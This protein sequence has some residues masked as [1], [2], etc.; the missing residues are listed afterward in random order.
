MRWL[1]RALF[2]ILL[3]VFVAFPYGPLFPWSRVTPGYDRLRLERADILHP[4]D[5]ALDPSYQDVDRFIAE[6]EQFHGLNMPQ[7]VTVVACRDW[8]DFQRFMPNMRSHGVGAVT[9]LTGTVIYVTP[10]IRERQL[11]NGEFL[12]HE[13]SHAALHQNQTLWNAYRIGKQKWF[14]EGLAVLFGR[15]RAYITPEEFVT[16][17]KNTELWPLF[18]GSQPSDMRFAYQG[19]RYFLD[20]LIATGGR[21]AFWRFERQCIADPDQCRTAFESV[22]GI[23]FQPAVTAFQNHLR[24]GSWSPVPVSKAAIPQADRP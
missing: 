14:A 17:A 9:L 1:R 22:Y 4:H 16:R 19:W 15:Q 10:R 21:A 7:R 2:A 20:H 11:D 8:A 18:D 12:R 3:L 24:D 5:S 13:L 6:A 23:G